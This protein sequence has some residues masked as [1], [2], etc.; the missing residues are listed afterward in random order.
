MGTGRRLQNFPGMSMADSVR[1]FAAVAHFCSESVWHWARESA[2]RISHPVSRGLAVKGL[3][4]SRY[5]SPRRTL[6]ATSRRYV[7]TTPASRQP[8]AKRVSSSAANDDSEI[9]LPAKGRRGDPKTPVRRV[10]ERFVGVSILDFY[11]HALSYPHTHI[12]T[13]G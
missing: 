9:T 13:M 7:A 12:P 6:P 10:S 1:A 4:D 2:C 11:T 3:A 5:A 8:N